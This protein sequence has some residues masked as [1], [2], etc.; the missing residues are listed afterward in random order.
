MAIIEFRVEGRV[1]QASAEENETILDCALR[2][3]VP[4]PY[5]C[6]EGVCSTCLAVIREGEAVDIIGSAPEVEADGVV[7][8]QTCQMRIKPGCEKLVVDYDAV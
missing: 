7:R 3:S 1:L 6:M 8:V 5:S 2:S 4:A